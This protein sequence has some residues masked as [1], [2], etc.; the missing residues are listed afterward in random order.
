MCDG[1]VGHRRLAPRAMCDGSMGHVRRL[2]GPQAA[3]KLPCA[4]TLSSL[5]AAV[6]TRRRRRVTSFAFNPG[7]RQ[8]ARLYTSDSL[9]D[10]G[11]PGAECADCIYGT[12]CADCGPRFPVPAS[13]AHVRRDVQRWASDADC[14]DCSPG[15]EFCEETVYVHVLYMTETREL[16]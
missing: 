1:S 7:A 9:C 11:G 8:R 2:H 6:V 5:D 4:T 13:T 14:N 16:K 10:D 12:D 15:S 3:G